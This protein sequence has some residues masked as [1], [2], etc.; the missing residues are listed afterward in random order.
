MFHSPLSHQL[1]AWS[2]ALLV[3]GGRFMLALRRQGQEGTKLDGDLFFL[4]GNTNNTAVTASI[5]Q[6]HFIS[7]SSAEQGLT[8]ICKV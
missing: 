2:S 7:S 8:P 3:S 4:S 1:L 6:V 5:S